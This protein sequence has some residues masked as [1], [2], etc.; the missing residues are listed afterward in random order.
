MRE[1]N[2]KQILVML[3]NAYDRGSLSKGYNYR[4]W[5]RELAATRAGQRLE[6][7]FYPL[8]EVRIANTTPCLGRGADS[9]LPA[10]PKHVRRILRRV[11]PRIVLACGKQAEEICLKLWPGDL[12]CIPHP[13]FRLLTNDLL[14]MAD[15]L[16]SWRLRLIA[17]PTYSLTAIPPLFRELVAAPK[18]SVALRQGRTGVVI[19]GLTR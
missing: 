15:Q 2:A 14:T 8:T 12:M 7:I 17:Q 16:M 3:Q 11:G 6:H 13:S 10:C 18:M 9:K 5:V 4:R 19:N 1:E